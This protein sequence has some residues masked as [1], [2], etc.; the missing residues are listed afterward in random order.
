MT[1]DLTPRE[2]AVLR[3]DITA[4]LLLRQAKAM[5]LGEEE[6]ERIIQ[7]EREKHEATWDE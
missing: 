7:A 1:S 3:A 6:A 2:L 5:G 4:R